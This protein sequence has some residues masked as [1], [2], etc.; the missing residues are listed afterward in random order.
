MPVKSKRHNYK[1]QTETF[2]FY[3]GV[4]ILDDNLRLHIK[5]L[6]KRSLLNLLAWLVVVIAI[7]IGLLLMFV[8]LFVEGILLLVVSVPFIIYLIISSKIAKEDEKTIYS[9]VV[10]KLEKSFAFSDLIGT[11]EHLTIDSERLTLSEDI[12]F[13]YF[14]NKFKSRVILYK[15]DDFN[16]KEFDNQKSRINRKANKQIGSK[17]WFTRS[18]IG[19]FMR[20]NIVYAN[21]LNDS[22]IAF[23]SRNA[24]QNLRRAEGIF[25]ISVIG[26]EVIIP[27]IYGD[28]DYGEISKY[29]KIIKLINNTW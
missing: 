1:N 5:K 24:G 3:K 12:H 19:S 21:E 23:L 28:C 2:V 29:E 16:K 17:Q 26:D 10:F 18:E 15:T 25:N 27:P 13:Y 4:E 20:F 14:E 9:P 6:K 22:L 8:S 11:L 7:G